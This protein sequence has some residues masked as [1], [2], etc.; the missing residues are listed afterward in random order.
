MKKKGIVLGAGYLGTRISNEL[1]YDSFNRAD[2][3]PLN[4]DALDLFLDDKKPDIVINAIGKTGRPNVDWCETNKEET[5]LANVVVA[6]NLGIEC[7]KRGIYF[8]HL[9]SGCMYCGDNNSIGFREEDE[10]NFYGPQ[11][12]AKTKILAEKILEEFPSL[13]LRIKMPIDNRPYERGLIDKLTRYS[14]VT[15]FKNSMI[16]IP[17][18]LKAIKSLIKKQAYGTYNLV[19][20]GAISPKEI[21]EMYTDIVDP[22]HKFE[23]CSPEDLG[24]A[25]KVR[26]ADCT[27]NTDKLKSEGVELP[28][29]HK[30]VKSCLLSYKR[31]KNKRDNTI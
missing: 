21:M 28:E 6:A 25:V 16:T 11:F 9:G 17:H 20:P 3:N 27:L 7:A 14:K 26:R 5:M 18:M 10:S 4:L 31:Y 23:A 12:Y 24:N 2:I 8:V 1:G 13:I 19:N 15:D 22:F 30:A 29:I